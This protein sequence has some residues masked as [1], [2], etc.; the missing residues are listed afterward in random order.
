MT[1]FLSHV[2]NSPEPAPAGHLQADPA[3]CHLA[4]QNLQD[5]A[6]TIQLIFRSL[7]P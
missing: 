3:L 4:A 5:T 6:D 7:L 2:H 1:V